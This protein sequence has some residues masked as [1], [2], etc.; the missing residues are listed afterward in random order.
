MPHNYTATGVRAAIE[1]DVAILRYLSWFVEIFPGAKNLSLSDCVEEFSKLMMLQLDMKIEADNLEKFRENFR[2]GTAESGNSTIDIEYIMR[3]LQGVFRGN[4]ESISR[5]RVTFPKPLR[6]FVT[7]DIL[8]ESYEPGRSISETT[9]DMN[10]VQLRREIATVGLD[11]I[12]KM[13]FEDNFI[14][15]GEKQ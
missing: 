4:M 7:R 1:A 6:P 14:H 13:V 11:A 9:A 5:Q 3:Y 8:V 10:D 12:L 2:C 15:A